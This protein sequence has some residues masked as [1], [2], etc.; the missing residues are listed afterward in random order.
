MRESKTRSRLRRLALLLAMI[1]AFTNADF[2][3]ALAA[4]YDPQFTDE[5]DEWDGIE[6]LED[7]SMLFDDPVTDE[8]A[9]ELEDIYIDEDMDDAPGDDSLE[10]QSS[11]D[12]AVLLS[13]DSAFNQSVEIDGILITVTADEGV[14]PSDAA[15][16]VKRILD[17]KELLKLQET[18]EEAEEKEEV[19]ESDPDGTGEIPE[20]ICEETPEEDVKPSNRENEED[21]S[22]AEDE[23]DPALAEAES[24]DDDNSNSEDAEA[25]SEIRSDMYAFDITVVDRDGNELQPDTDKGSVKVAF[26]NPD[27]DSLDNDEYDIYHID[28]KKDKAEKLETSVEQ[29]MIT[30]E[31]DT[32][33][34]FVLLGASNVVTLHTGL[35]VIEDIANWQ[36]VS[37]KPEENDLS[38]KFESKRSV[39]AFPTPTCDET[40]L[41]FVGWYDNKA[42]T[43]TKITTPVAGKD[44]YAL[45]KRTKSSATGTYMTYEYKNSGST[46]S[47]NS[48]GILSSK[49]GGRTTTSQIQ[50][51]YAN[52]G[53]RAYYKLNTSNATGGGTGLAVVT[54]GDP[55]KQVSGDLY[56]ATS[57]SLEDKFVRYSYYIWNK[58]NS[59]VN[60]F[61]IGLAADVQ[62]GSNDY[63]PL[64]IYPRQSTTDPFADKYVVMTDGTNEFRLYYGGP[65]VQD[66][67]TL[68]TGRY[69]S[70]TSNV[71]TNLQKD[72]SGI[73]ST[74][75]VSWKNISIPA[76]ETVC[77]SI[78]LGAGQAGKVVLRKRIMIDKNG[79]G[80][81]EANEIEYVTEGQTV[82]APAAPDRAGYVFVEWNTRPDG[83]GTSYQP[84][85]ALP[86]DEDITLHPIMYQ[87]LNTAD[88][89]LKLD[90]SLWPGQRVEL[91]QGSALKYTLDDLG[92]AYSNSAVI[93]GTYDVYVNRLNTGKTLT[94]DATTDSQ[95]KAVAVSYNTV[96]AKLKLNDEYT[97]SIGT[98]TLRQSGV[99]KYTMFWDSEKDAFIQYIQSDNFAN[100]GSYDIFIEGESIGADYKLNDYYEER[101]YHNINISITDDAP[102]TDAVVTLRSVTDGTIVHTPEYRAALT[103]RNTTHYIRLLEENETE[104]DVYINGRDMHTKVAAVTEKR[105]AAFT[106]YSARIELDGITPTDRISM[107]NGVEY[108]EF[109]GPYGSSPAAYALNHVLVN[110]FDNEGNPGGDEKIYYVTIPGITV[111]ETLTIDS[112]HK[113]LERGY[114][115]V[116]FHNYIKNKTSGNY[117]W[118]VVREIVVK[119]GETVPVYKGNVL[120][121]GMSFAWWS[122]EK[123]I[124]GAGIGAEYDYST[125]VIA[126]VNLYA[127]YSYP[128][129]A[130]N[131]VVRTNSD[132]SV[133]GNSGIYYKM[134]NL[135]IS[136]FDPG[137]ESIKYL[138]INGTN[139]EEINILP[140]S[141]LSPV[142]KDGAMSKKLEFATPISMAEAQD[143]L[144]NYVLIKP[145][146][147]VEHTLTVKALD[148]DGTYTEGTTKSTSVAEGVYVL[149][150]SSLRTGTYVVNDAVGF[151]RTGSTGNAGLSVSGDVY[152]YIPTNK[153]LTVTGGAGSGQ[154]GGGPGIY[155]PSG[156]NLYLLGNGTATIKGGRGGNGG[157]GNNGASATY[158]SSSDNVSLK[159]GGSGGYGGGGSGAGIGSGG[160]SGGAGGSG[161]SAWSID[162]DDCGNGNGGSVGSAGNDTSLSM[163]NVYIS[164]SLTKSIQ[165]GDAGSGGGSGS[166]GTMSQFGKQGDDSR[167][168][169]GSAGGGG[170]GGGRKGNAIG[171]GGAGG[172]GGGGGASAGYI[173][174]KYGIGAG[175]GGGGYGGN[176]GYGGYGS[177]SEYIDYHNNDG[178]GEV[179]GNGGNGGSPGNG[180]TGA[181][182]WVRENNDSH[183]GKA[184]NG[185]NGGSSGTTGGS[186]NEQTYTG[187][188]NYSIT[189]NVGSG[190]HIT[191]GSYTLGTPKTF[192]L[193]EYSNNDR[194][195][196]FKGWQLTRFGVYDS[197][198]SID[199]VKGTDKL[200]PVGQS[201]TIPEG[202]AG[203]LVFT[204][205]TDTMAGI[206]DDDTVSMTIHEPMAYDT[207]TVTVEVDGQRQS[208]GTIKIGNNIVAPG[209]DKTYVYTKVRKASDSVSGALPITVNGQVIPGVT[210]SANNS[211][212]VKY[213]TIKV[214]VSGKHPSAV[215][216]I[217]DDAPIL[218]EEGV[219][220]ANS[221]DWYTFSAIRLKDESL[222]TSYPI[223]VDGK[224]AEAT[225][226]YGE[227]CDIKYGTITVNVTPAGLTADELET[228][229]LRSTDG[230]ETIFLTRKP[231]DGSPVVFDNTLLPTGRTYN[232]FINGEKL[233]DSYN[234]SFTDDAPNPTKNITFSRYTTTVH[235]S[236]NGEPADLGDL[237]FGNTRMNKNSTG[238]YSIVTYN[239][240]SAALKLDSTVL[241]TSVAAGSDNSF[242]YY[243]LSYVYSNGTTMP[244]SPEEGL[245][246]TDSTIYRSGSTVTLKSG[247]NLSNGG[248]TFAGWSING[249]GARAPGST[250]TI[251]NTDQTTIKAVWVPTPFNTG[252]FNVELSQTD[253][254]YNGYSQTPTVRVLRGTTELVQGVDYELSFSNDLGDN[255]SS[256]DSSSTRNAGKIKITVT[257][258]GDYSGTLTQM[259]VEDYPDEMPSEGESTTGT[260]LTDIAFTIHKRNITV[261]GLRARDRIYDG[262]IIVQLIKEDVV[263]EGLVVGDDV[264]LTASDTAEMYSPTARAHKAVNMHTIDLVG[265]DAANYILDDLDPIYVNIGRKPLTAD[266]F[267]LAASVQYDG[268]EQTPAIT[269]TDTDSINGVSVN[270]ISENDYSVTYTD[271]KNVGIA[272][273]TIT[274][275]VPETELDQDGNE[276]IARD[277]EGNIVYRDDVN[278]SGTITKT[279]EITKAPV[280]IKAKDA[281]SA[282]G[283]DIAELSYE[284]TNG[285]IHNDDLASLDI[286]VSTEVQK[287]YSVGT[288]TDK[289][290]ISYTPSDNY[291][292]TTQPGT[293]TVTKAPVGN[294]MIWATAYGYSGIYD[295]AAH[296]ITV[297]PGSVLENEELTITYSD[298]ENGAYS[299]DKPVYANAGTYTTYYKVTSANVDGAVT[300]SATVTISKKPVTLTAKQKTIKYGDAPENDGYTTDGFVD[301]HADSPTVTYTYT[302]DQYG[303]VG[304]YSIIPTAI[305]TANYTYTCLPGTLKV[306]PKPVTLTWSANAVTIKSG[307]TAGITATVVETV[308]DDVIS[309]GS[310]S[311]N[312][313][314]EA[315]EYTAT[316]NGLAGEKAANYVLLDDESTR[317]HS[318]TVSVVGEASGDGDK[319]PLY[320]QWSD[321]S[322]IYNGSQQGVTATFYKLGEN[323]VH[324]AVTGLTPVYALTQEFTNTAT[325]VG[326]YTAKVTG[327]FGTDSDQYKLASENSDA[328]LDWSIAKATNTVSAPTLTSS[329]WYYGDVA[330][331]PVATST[332]GEVY[333]E[334]AS[335]NNL[336]D[337]IFKRWSEEVPSAAGTYKVRAKV[338]GTSDYDGT[339]SEMISFTISPAV[340][341]VTAVDKSSIYGAE[342]VPLTYT[343]MVAHGA[344][345][346]TEK[347][348]L[349][350]TA[351][352][353]ATSSSNVG[354]YT[355]IPS[356][357]TTNPNISA[358]TVNGA[359]SITRSNGMSASVDAAGSSHVY[360]R[361]GHGLGAVTVTGINDQSDSSIS[362]L[363]IYYSTEELNAGNYGTGTATSPTFTDVGTYK[364]HYYIIADNYS[365]LSGSSNVTIT[366]RSREVQLENKHVT[367]GSSEWKEYTFVDGQIVTRYYAVGG[368][369]NKVVTKATYSDSNEN[370]TYLPSDLY[371]DACNLTGEDSFDSIFTL[372]QTSYTYDGTPRTPAVIANWKPFGEASSIIT[373]D[374]YEVT[375]SNNIEKGTATVIITGKRN[376]TGTFTKTF[377][378]GQK[379]VQI[380]A[381]AAESIYGN[382]ISE[383]S[384]VATPEL[385][386][387]DLTALRPKAATTAKK[388]YSVGTYPIT[389]SFRE[390]ENYNIT[391]ID[392]VYTVRAA[393]LTMV[394]ENYE[395]IY[396][397]RA[398]AASVSAKT[399]RLS[400]SA[401]IYYSNAVIDGSTVLTE[402]MRNFPEI[403][404]AG[405]HIVYYSAVC[406]NYNSAYG[407]VKVKLNKATATVTVPDATLTYGEDPADVMNSMVSE[408]PASSLN[409]SGLK[410][411]DSADTIFGSS[412]ISYSTDYVRYGDVSSEDNVYS[413]IGQGLSSSNYDVEYISGRLTVNPK[414]ITT[415]TWPETTSLSYTGK[416]QGIK[417]TL[418][419]I[420]TC[421]RNYVSA[422]YETGL[423]ESLF[424]KTSAVD[425]GDYTAKITGI[426][427]EKASNYTLDLDND[428][429]TKSWSIVKATDNA[430]I[431]TAELLYATGNGF[432]DE[433]DS[434]NYIG[435]AKYGEVAVKTAIS[436]DSVNNKYTMQVYVPGTD[437]YDGLDP[438]T[439]EYTRST[440]TT[441]TDIS[442]MPAVYYGDPMPEGFND[443]NYTTNYKQGSPAGTY[444]ITHKPSGD[445]NYRPATFTVYP[446]SVSLSWSMNIF[447][448]DGTSKVVTAVISNVFG[449]DDVEVSSYT[450]N[451][452]TA[453]GNYTAV[454][455]ALKGVDRNNYTLE[456]GTYISHVWN[457]NADDNNSFTRQVSLN[458]WTYGDDAN[459]PVAE[460][461]Y[462][463]E[464]IT[465]T[466]YLDNNGEISSDKTS[467]GNS[468]ALSEGGVPVKAGTYWVVAT[469]AG[470]S[471]YSTV[472]S[473][474][475]FTIA[476]R[477]IV[478]TAKD[479][480]GAYGAE[481]VDLTGTDSYVMTG[482]LVP[483]DN[484]GVSVTTT[485]TNRSA[486]G[487]YPIRI[488]TGGIGAIGAENY[489]VTSYNGIYTITNTGET[490]PYSAADYNGIYD[491]LPHGITVTPAPEAVNSEVYY[492]N[493][494]LTATN[495]GSGY[496]VSPVLTNVGTATVY[497]YITADNYPS[498]AGSKTITI[499]QKEVTVTAMPKTITYGEAPETGAD[500]V[501]YSGFEGSDTAVS[502]SLSPTYSYSYNQY[503][504]ATDAGHSYTITP[505]VT[506][507][508]NYTFTPVDGVLT[509]EPKEVTLRWNKD[510]FTY[511]STEKSVTAKVTN[512]ES[513]DNVVVATYENN[514]KV[515]VDSYRARAL[516]LSGDKAG[517]YMINGNAD[518][519]V[520]DWTINT[521]VN[522]FKSEPTVPSWYYGD[523]P[524]TPISQPDFGTPEYFFSESA[525]GPFT[526]TPPTNAG[527]YYVKAIVEGTDNYPELAS[528][529]V[530]FTIYPMEITVTADDQFSTKGTSL[531]RLTYSLSRQPIAG[532]RFNVSINAK[533]GENALTGN[534]NV[535]SYPINVS[536]DT[537]SNYKA[538][539]KNGT[540]HLL[541]ADLGFNVKVEGGGSYEYDGKHHGIEVKITD[542]QEGITPTVYYTTIPLNNPSVS[543][544]QSS[545]YETSPER[546]DVGSTTIYY[547]I[548]KGDEVVAAGSSTVTIVKR[549]ITVTAKDADIYYNEDPTN[550]GVTYA[551][552][553]NGETDV[554]IGGKLSYTYSYK[555]GDPAGSYTITPKGLSSVNYNIHYQSGT[556]TVWPTR[557]TTTIEVTGNV[558]STEY[559]GE[560]IKGFSTASAA[561]GEITESELIVTYQ[562]SDGT[563]LQ[564]APTEPGSYKVI[565][566]IPNTNRNYVAQPKEISFSIS[567]ATLDVYARDLVV[568]VGDSLSDLK[569]EYVRTE[570]VYDGFKGS[571]TRSGIFGERLPTVAYTTGTSTAGTYNDAIILS[572]LPSDK[573]SIRY[574]PGQLKVVSKTKD[575]MASDITVKTTQVTNLSSTQVTLNGFVSP[576]PIV[577]TATTGFSYK[578]LTDK[579]ETRVS[580]VNN[581]DGTI[582]YNLTVSPDTDYKFYAF[583]TAKN[584]SEQSG[585]EMYFHV[586][587][588]TTTP[589]V[590]GTGTIEVNIT[591]DSDESTVVLVTIEKGSNAIASKTGTTIVGQPANIEP[592]SDLEDGWYNVVVRTLDG[593]F[594]E[595]RMIA[596][597]VNETA[598]IDFHIPQTKGSMASI[599]N[600]MG[601][602]T[603]PVA[604]DGLA[605]IIT[606]EQKLEV[607]LGK[608]DV[609][610]KLDVEKKAEEDVT[611]S[612]ANDIKALATDD[613]VIDTFLDISLFR[614]ISR[615]E[616]NG[617]VEPGEPKKIGNENT[618]V[619]EIAVP[620]DTQKAGIVV[621]RKHG[622]S[623]EAFVKCDSKPLK[624]DFEDG[625]YYVDT[626][627]KYIF[628]YASKYSTYAIG[629]DKTEGGGD[630]GG[631]GGGGGGGGEAPKPI[632]PPVINQPEHGKITIAPTAPAANETVIITVEA[633]E[634][635]EVE[636]IT[637]TDTDGNPITVIKNEDG[638]Y[639]FTHPS[640]GGVIISANVI[641]KDAIKVI[642]DLNG[643]E[644]IAPATQAI[645]KGQ[646]ATR[647]SPDPTS[648]G[649]KFID[650]YLEP[651]C[652]N[653]YDFDTAVEE[654]ITLYAGWEKNEDEEN[655]DFGIYFAELF[656]NPY[657]GVHYNEELGRYEIVY[658]SQPIKPLIRATSKA[659][660]VLREGI[661]YTV[662]YSNNRNISK[663]KPATIRV[664]GKGYY[665]SKK[666]LELHILPADLGEAKERGLLVHP[667]EMNVKSGKKLVP[668]IVYSG[669]KLKSKDYTLS[670]KLAI[671]EDTSITITG[672]GNFT[673]SIS[674]IPVKVVT[675][676]TV[677][678]ANIKVKLNAKA[679]VF[680]GKPQELKITSAEEPGELT[681]TAGSSKEILEQGKD[682]IVSYSKNIDAGKAKVMVTGIGNYKGSVVK[683][684]TIKPDRESEAVAGLSNPDAVVYYNVR[685]AVP[686][687]SVKVNRTDASDSTETYELVEGKDYKLKYSNNKKV[688]NGRCRIT[689]INNYK[690]H[691]GLTVTYEISRASIEGAR[692]EA[693]DL[694]YKKPGKY[695]S[696]PYVS[697]DG[698]Q[699]KKSDYTF[700]YYVGDRELGSNEKLTLGTEENDKV[701]T[702]VV[703]GRGNYSDTKASG[704]YTVIRKKTE[705]IDFSKAKIVAKEKNKKGKNVKVGKK[706]YTGYAIEPEIR[707]MVKINKKWTDVD[708]SL[709]TVSYINNINKGNATIMVTGNG[710]ETIGS[711]TVRFRITTMRMN[712]FKVIFG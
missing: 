701:V 303:N 199:L 534:D 462:G 261:T 233:D 335:A 486:A 619:L 345:S 508:Q 697:I 136:G 432:P 399:V 431:V 294:N 275:E 274:A 496:S 611:G 38:F 292:I 30:A 348:G 382:A 47:I 154:T 143:F 674:D 184:G 558:V 620:F 23:N 103:S 530:P 316:A 566:T 673:G 392:A 270:L 207:Y 138:F 285:S 552:F 695:R 273:V 107:T 711:K 373:E 518:T 152:I 137:V 423:I 664:T 504:A 78:L 221:V 503:G 374:D 318:F 74:L 164:T 39:T 670:N 205:I 405:T 116:S 542:V 391:V 4:D 584:K 443:T 7:E 258:K 658:T 71:F 180:G 193:P 372:S 540:Y 624:A 499:T 524:H 712:L 243:K 394:T 409:V 266:M 242:Y 581:G 150:G 571:D 635:Y 653:L 595:T 562:K 310:Y 147:N 159:A 104:Y 281:T 446:R 2:A 451:V 125:P 331:S 383:L 89:T 414:E 98:I 228:V 445:T 185:G 308:N 336:T 52:Y 19:S 621:Y 505:S 422:T 549:T 641:L 455:T 393:D 213:E 389:V 362:G 618:T 487:I 705:V 590:P 140:G 304:C 375:Y 453:A 554:N 27:S 3:T 350:I 267:S 223:Y 13:E 545:G 142:A 132:G 305:D 326:R 56:V 456:N 129:I 240:S 244:S 681:V 332:F 211:A 648:K 413:I 609:E 557:R 591:T 75:T 288:Y 175:G 351:S 314:T 420:E 544:V 25:K 603:P 232:V 327:F 28:E 62:I 401:T 218:M 597:S 463:T 550:N 309:V 525:N 88:V 346:E 265:S 5:T 548:I 283:A 338:D 415:V 555:K 676:Q 328:V 238:V 397:G 560:P 1:L 360:D 379:S 622:A 55:F 114:N 15:L 365:P 144:R 123:I 194:K 506:A 111:V 427:G 442:G 535:G 426:T 586:P 65:T 262:T 435:I 614:T 607:A 231:G 612:D 259:T 226:A 179:S 330:P 539:T 585:K 299:A 36:E 574:H 613:K 67:Q 54:S 468:G 511:D 61:N 81:I 700:R 608:K 352:T 686:A 683:T 668:T 9:D 570:V 321:G 358:E 340:V 580:A 702:I 598:S 412:M 629:Y 418:N 357:T 34:P 69:S 470:T 178:K 623:P 86:T 482:S 371:V 601:N 156:S 68:W 429:R 691:A 58:G 698:V 197:V 385:T 234:I 599:V 370:V 696:A 141:S 60:N 90:G 287:G 425:V 685:G 587:S 572:G 117:D 594:T 369:Y 663:K 230:L 483:G 122:T 14:F 149:S 649:Y 645:V 428:A 110:D 72:Q 400:D 349:G 575:T 119:Y 476:K 165:A 474:V 616:P 49:S 704:T 325:N 402:D 291:N 163:G 520:H 471:D 172:G 637:V 363:T 434:L 657:D 564:A 492:G 661:D 201:F 522:S 202:M 279:F 272:T 589:S 333:F 8:E 452:N 210:V 381:I 183:K 665:K 302:Y 312:T 654:D 543:D 466:Y 519:T 63:A 77:K 73:D 602:D 124:P 167:G 168:A 633:D 675:M 135:T 448:Y 513:T 298:A 133:N 155:L 191:E 484:L 502:E 245:L 569:D 592:F 189:Y 617:T 516:T 203:D 42:C 148:R 478:L 146:T 177:T 84:G 188:V 157:K 634:G 239:S 225:V 158:S 317:T 100:E 638:T 553:E 26:S 289:I 41:Q 190:N 390:N 337:N 249:S 53:Y 559:T 710:T 208:V 293:Y 556:L 253:F 526:K 687:I 396:D 523:E 334:Y 437:N 669:Y 195:V 236:L 356:I 80:N 469:V 576:W 320:V 688:G 343:Y 102:W 485:A 537:T 464:G 651:Q 91:Y 269:A 627:L 666:V 22:S 477:Q 419:G 667:D 517:S 12:E 82:P 219:E 99:T 410:T 17:E 433:A 497:Y 436:Y 578:K 625:R 209:A 536:V 216:L 342:L 196:N 10:L 271:N 255:D 450:D 214:R 672:R 162:K 573:Y 24:E 174:S 655:E 366:K 631:G 388:G 92:G 51:T 95:R 440:T 646:K 251:N 507:T 699:L 403:R 680:N 115:K 644:G 44:Y 404:D 521:G 494:E 297:T 364:V 169:S 97:D 480:T 109:T 145:K 659:D 353:D 118:E 181:N 254:T 206:M 131:D 684:F 171:A 662:S 160:A 438:V 643:K 386:E 329:T 127:Q 161:G 563:V 64:T 640:G 532:D 204:A 495:Y 473:S 276:V 430:W 703:T 709:Y 37:A 307:E 173:W 449:E 636:N 315:G 376:L 176:G 128:T 593:E 689:F 498:V 344:V 43:G 192:N 186:K 583:A 652:L 408:H 528:K 93:N 257:G 605:D 284:V 579:S 35:G 490:L 690:G 29:E 577:D 447:T 395:G 444:T 642:F 296:G 106:F 48:F 301:G 527:K 610:I 387:D 596:V 411:G 18:V 679:H 460:A 139:I 481:I 198:K 66:A 457:I 465:Y 677:K 541:T 126:N 500:D 546:R 250:F 606:P 424:Y 45:W 235:T 656:D 568:K 512:L 380:N 600:V 200:Y 277:H 650:W 459:I 280:T 268:T 306:D 32:F 682:F 377:T 247:E 439:I 582:S 85:D 220:T 671:R 108:Y 248:K 224:D 378:I 647:P 441:N 11:P 229:E 215:T 531:N 50:T 290:R 170:G 70:H 489:E 227:I 311:G 33:S 59:D 461:K 313:A 105:D 693:K 264:N 323:S 416:E 339:V 678:E 551:G 707:V 40:T 6:V 547:Y 367:F 286:R 384:Y 130:I 246:P 222:T 134:S 472:T 151:T 398:H 324:V 300:G 454:A 295:G 187:S 182:G 626:L 31:A 475:Q 79:N 467:S 421:D 256:N 514:T 359:Y 361:N 322:L 96:T 567:F 529:P 83:S 510:S 458:G 113:L 341:K 694:I 237:Y 604:V 660:G 639:S 217:G 153:T 561:G 407:L 588:T 706:E 515:D 628:I 406:E 46:G 417:A 278:Y 533:N 263:L 708:P 509:V 347:T 16:N 241:E 354:K 260:K 493:S 101:T 501:R 252:D 319:T 76:G 692:V 632:V 20:Q 565:L 615:I 121:S 94:F 355:I 282:Y 21:E 630:S 491:G 368:P 212:V 166:A 538:I 112:D 87:V 479:Q 120:Y 57:A 488:A